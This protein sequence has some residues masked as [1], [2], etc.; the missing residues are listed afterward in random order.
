MYVAIFLFMQIYKKKWE[1]GTAQQ[2]YT[3][4]NKK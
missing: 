1:I 4:F 2:V 3:T